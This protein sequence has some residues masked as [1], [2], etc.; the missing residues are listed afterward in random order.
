[1]F[2]LSIKISPEEISLSLKS[3]A[4]IEL[5]PAPVR[6]TIPIF[7]AGLV[8]NDTPFKEGTK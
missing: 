5:L 1:M 7:S 8:V 3:E 2:T 4:R 6:P